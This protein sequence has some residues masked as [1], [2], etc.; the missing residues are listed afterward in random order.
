MDFEVRQLL[1]QKWNKISYSGN[2]KVR[3]FIAGTAAKH[4][5][6]ITLELRIKSNVFIDNTIDLQVA[7]KQIIFGKYGNNFSEACIS[8]Y[9]PRLYS[10]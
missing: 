5:T 6:P 4:L 9:F 3:R 10:T 8:M 7:L 2:S 1:K